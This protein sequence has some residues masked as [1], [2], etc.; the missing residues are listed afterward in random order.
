MNQLGTLFVYELLV[1]ALC[2]SLRCL[3][4]M[5][6]GHRIGESRHRSRVGGSFSRGNS[7]AKLCDWIDLDGGITSAIYGNRGVWCDGVVWRRANLMAL[8]YRYVL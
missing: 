1:D 6:I 8:G 4:G 7:E 3:R 2:M 5:V